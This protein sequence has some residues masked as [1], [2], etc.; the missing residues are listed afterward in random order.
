MLHCLVLFAIQ[1]EK[2]WLV[3]V[4]TDIL[5]AYTIAWIAVKVYYLIHNIIMRNEALK[6]SQLTLTDFKR[7][8]EVF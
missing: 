4:K 1:G 3:V 6:S 2:G 8:L 5:R 7:Y